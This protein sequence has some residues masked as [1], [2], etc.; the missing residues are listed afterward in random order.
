MARARKNRYQPLRNVVLGALVF[1][2]LGAIVG[3]LAQNILI[4]MLTGYIVGTEYSVPVWGMYCIYGSVVAFIALTYVAD[5][6][7]ENYYLKKIR[8]TGK[9]PRRRYS[10]I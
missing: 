6:E 9:L 5:K 1:L 3:G 2:T 7:L 10:H 4:F 8:S